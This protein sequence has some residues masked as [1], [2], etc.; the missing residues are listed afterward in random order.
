MLNCL[1]PTT[2]SDTTEAGHVAGSSDEQYEMN[3]K[4]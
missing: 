1:L 3:E 2:R 4:S